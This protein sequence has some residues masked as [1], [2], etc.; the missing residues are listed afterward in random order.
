M[1][2]GSGAYEGPFSF[3]TRFEE[4]PGTNPEELIGAALAGCFSMA[5]SGDLGRAGFTPEHVATSA[6]VHLET[7]NG[8]A[9]ITRIE[10]A[11]EA[12]VPGIDEAKFN[13]IANGTK[14]VPVSRAL[15]SVQILLNAHC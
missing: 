15:G 8:A 9:T 5:F 1:A 13:E 6:K 2:L 14:R 7:V 11:M 3:S 10:L 12:K 4:E